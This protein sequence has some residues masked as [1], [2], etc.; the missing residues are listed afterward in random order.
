MN[1]K[2]IVCGG[3]GAGKSTLG[4]GLAEELGWIFKDIEEYY[5]PADNSDYH[6]SHARTREEVAKRLLVDMKKYDDLIL[7][8][9]KG[10]YGPEV[11]KL[12]T[13]AILID[14]PRD[15]R[16]ERVKTRSNQKFG[17]RMLPGGDLYEK[18]EHF[19]DMVQKRPED[20]VTKWL[21]TVDIPVFR[22]DGT[23]AIEDNIEMIKKELEKMQH[24]IR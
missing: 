18:E 20:Y 19:F 6:Y 24:E 5:F 4:K 9:V 15:I 22:V 23:H 10:D 13:F 1:N 17:D 16:M 3:N 21:D 7:A 14:V 2:I 8:S 12:F 11:L